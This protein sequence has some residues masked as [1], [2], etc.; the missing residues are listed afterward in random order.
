MTY[1]RD[2][3]KLLLKIEAMRHILEQMDNLVENLENRLWNAMDQEKK[4]KGKP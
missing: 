4:P 2:L 3:S 1:Q